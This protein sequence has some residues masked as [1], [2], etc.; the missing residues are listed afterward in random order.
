MYEFQYKHTLIEISREKFL[1]TISNYVLGKKK[2]STLDFIDR[3]RSPFLV[4][5]VHSAVGD[6]TGPG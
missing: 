3:Q 5:R 1:W 2:N 4:N 6:V